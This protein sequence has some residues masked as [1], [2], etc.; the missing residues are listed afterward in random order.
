MDARIAKT[1]DAQGLVYGWAS[2]AIKDG[3][4]IIDAQG[5]MIDPDALEKA[6]VD[7]MLDYR[8]SGAMHQGEAVGTIVESVVMS[9]EKAQL[10]FGGDVSKS[11]P[12]GL[13]I[14]VKLDPKG[15]TF[16]KVKAGVYKMFSVQGLAAKVEV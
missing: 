5:D 15:D 3:E 14:G 9:P 4:Q 1:D 13:W 16:Q 2:V 10:M 12:T 6:A 7:F 8:T 11:I